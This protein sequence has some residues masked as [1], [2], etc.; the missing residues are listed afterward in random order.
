MDGSNK[1]ATTLVKRLLPTSTAR[2]TPMTL[3]PTLFPISESKQAMKTPNCKFRDT[4]CD[5]ACEN[6]TDSE[7]MLIVG[8]NG[9]G[10]KFRPTE[11]SQRIAG[12]VSHFQ[13][14]HLTYSA[15]VQP[16]ILMDGTRAVRLDSKLKTG[17]PEIFEQIMSFVREN[18]LTIRPCLCESPT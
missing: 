15:C 17:A 2:C 10:T 3:F 16:E 9:D 1:T 11:W 5:G 12:L 4:H 6:A 8:R 18:G 7:C 13:E 14:N